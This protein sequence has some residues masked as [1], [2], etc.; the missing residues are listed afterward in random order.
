MPKRPFS[1]FEE[2][3]KVNAL[4]EKN[5][6]KAHEVSI[7]SH[8][9]AKF[10]C[11]NEECG[12]DFELK[13]NNVTASN[14]WCPCCTGNTLCNKTLCIPCYNKSFA[15]FHNKDKVNALSENNEFKAHEVS[16]SSGKQSI[17]KC[18]NEECGREFELTIND[19]TSSNRWCPCCNGV[20]ICN[21]NLCIPCY[22]KS[23]ASFHNKD[24][25]NA[26][27]EKNEFKAHEVSIS[28]N[29]KAIFKCYNEECDREFEL[30]LNHVTASNM[31]CPCC[32]GPI[33]CNKTLCIPCYGKSFASFRDKDKVNSLS[34]KNEFKA[35]EVSISSGKKAI[36]KCYNEECGREFELKI[37]H[38]TSS[39]R[40]CPCCNGVA[41]CNKNLCIP[42]YNKSFASFHNK[43]KV[44]A[45]S[46]KNE[47]KANEVSIS[48]DKK[49]IFKC[50]KCDHEFKTKICA[51]SNG[52][53]CK[54]C[55]ASK[56]KFI[57]KLFEI[58]DGMGMKYDVEVIVKCENHL[59]RW[60]MVVY[61]KEREFH[62]E[63]DGKQHFSVEGLIS[64]LR[65]N[66][67]NKKAQK[68][69]K[70]RREK[71]LLKEKHIVDNNKLLFRISYKQFDDLEELV[72][73]MI[74][75]S[76]KKSKGVVKMDDIYDW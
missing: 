33:L 40:W 29:K 13:L 48:A 49:A 23:F 46:E 14:M 4:S 56:N 30:K 8:K 18:Y 38:V 71:D 55:H 26:L 19:V 16:I 57:R 63:S 31:W 37:K 54:F 66:I 64:F 62:I 41:I 59:L 53:W 43:D 21:K 72:K 7:S 35:N 70:D 25:V 9:K 11:Y 61:N 47:F 3:D 68:E 39:N 50:Y 36:F 76:N 15:S 65:T 51:I 6:F 58:F 42:C 52:Q 28:S 67:S 22:S 75:K 5:E 1:D 12:R 2:I 44:N 34:E 24:K 69:F 17:F 10:E 73:E 45:L 32:T 20:A 27:S 60:D 74:S